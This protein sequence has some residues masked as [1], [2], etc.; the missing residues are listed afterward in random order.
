MLS[1]HIMQEA[2][3]VCHRIIILNRGKIIADDTPAN[4][5][6]FTSVKVQKVFGRICGNNNTRF[7][8]QYPRSF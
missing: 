7:T 3:A 2:E 5:K 8:C 6:T 1:T 4:I